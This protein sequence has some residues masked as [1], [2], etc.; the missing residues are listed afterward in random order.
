MMEIQLSEL[1]DEAC[2]VSHFV[3]LSE[4]CTIG[5]V[6]CVL[7]SASGRRY[8]GKCIDAACG[9][10]FCAEHAAIG[11]MVTS[12][13]SQII[14]AVAVNEEGHVVPPCGRCREFMM[15]LNALNKD[16]RVLINDHE[17]VSLQ[18]LLPYY[19]YST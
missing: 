14:W 6:G 3:K 15:Q 9:I 16:A 12:G 18:S 13:E 1:I 2:R 17:H 8:Y 11:Q 4:L 10:G 19:W 7:I 5:G